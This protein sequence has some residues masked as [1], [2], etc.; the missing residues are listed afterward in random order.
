VGVGENS[1]DQWIVLDRLPAA[2]E[3]IQASERGEGAG[4]QIDTALL[5][6][7]RLG[8]SAAYLGVV[9]AD[10]EGARVL[11]PLRAARVDCSGVQVVPAA[12]TRRAFIWVDQN[13][14]R[15]ICAARDPELRLQVERLD[16]AWIES[17]AL[18]LLDCEDLDL[19]HWAISRA[20]AASV[21][22]ML[23]ADRWE[24]AHRDLLRGVDFPIVSGAVA[25]G[26]AAADELGEGLREIMGPRTV[27]A[28][29]T[30]G[31]RGATARLG[32]RVLEQSPP[33]VEVLDTTGA[34]DVF[35]GCF[36]W[37]LHRG[38]GAAGVLA[39]AV[40]GAALS[41]SGR[42][43]QGQLPSRDA[44]LASPG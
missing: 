33:P 10:A 11:A 13:G 34:G 20:R 37:A 36:A 26:L 43:A 12:A 6:C 23:D 38:L 25:R 1:W 40:R 30:L 41:C 44:L 2:G 19:A 3:K 7:A 29:A 8:L 9:G 15:T 39:A 5:C 27:M 32:S 4:G 17:G 22:V 28:T 24:P 21:P 18:L 35:R 31:A 16:S 42:G 14:E